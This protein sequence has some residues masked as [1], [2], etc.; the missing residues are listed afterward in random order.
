MGSSALLSSQRESGSYQLVGTRTPTFHE[1]HISPVTFRAVFRDAMTVVSDTHCA[2]LPQCLSARH[3]ALSLAQD[4][5]LAELGFCDLSLFSM[6]SS[7]AC[8]TC[9]LANMIS[10]L[11]MSL[12]LIHM[13][14]KPFYLLEL[15]RGSH[16][17]YS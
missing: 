13:H 17:P 7:E 5:L 4:L 12:F 9:G 10:R 6:R 15:F 11:D 2:C 16:V 3:P 14:P 1:G 8:E